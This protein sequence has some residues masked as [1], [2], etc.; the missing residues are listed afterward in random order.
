MQ[1]YRACVAVFRQWCLGAGLPVL[2]WFGVLGGKISD[3]VVIFLI[4]A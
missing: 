4:R 1:F 3:D 2:F